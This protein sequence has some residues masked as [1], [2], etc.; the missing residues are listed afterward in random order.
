MGGRG[1][2][3]LVALV[4]R[5]LVAAGERPAILSRG[6]GRRIREDGVVI[7]SDGT[8]ICADV[9]RAGDE[10][11]LLAHAVPGA[12]VLVCEQR[13]MAAALAHTALHTTINV[14]DDGFQHRSMKRDLDVVVITPGDL[15]DRRVPFGRLRQSP[16]ALRA[17]DA[18]VVDGRREDADLKAFSCPVFTLARQL[19]NPVPIE[20]SRPAP[21]RGAPIV[22]AA[23]IAQPERFSR[24]LE[25]AGWTVAASVAFPDHHRFTRRDLARLE[26]TVTTTGA[27][28]VLTTE[29]DAI[30]WRLLRPLPMPIAA[31]PLIVTVEPA[32]EFE[33]WLLGR[34]RSLR[35]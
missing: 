10:P 12:A 24:A 18:I 22:A 8:H 6:Y 13:A 28:G 35:P 20:P 19:G 7:V 31:V 2:T 34:L 32:A 25:A 33:T 1:K 11:L 14:L 3:P 30:R 15:R 4:A 16:S 26:Q 23:G 21:G 5:M 27:H 29:K 9:D 17:A